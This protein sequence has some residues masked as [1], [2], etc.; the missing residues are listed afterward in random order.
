MLWFALLAL[1]GGTVLCL[2]VAALVLQPRQ[3]DG[4]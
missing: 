3:A 4:Q 1:G 2:G